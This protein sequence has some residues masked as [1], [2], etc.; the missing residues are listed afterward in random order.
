MTRTHYT[1]RRSALLPALLFLILSAPIIPVA[2]AAPEMRVID[3][4][5]G[6]RQGFEGRG[7]DVEILTVTG[8]EALSGTK[9]LLVTNRSKAWHGPALNVTYYVDPDVLYTVSVHVLPK[10]P[11]SS[12]FRLSTQIGEGDGA[13]FFNLDKQTVSR[14]DGWTELQGRFMYSEADYITIYIE[15]DTPDAEFYI[16]DVSF[17]AAGGGGGILASISLPSLREIYQDHFLLGSAFSRQDLAGQRFELVKRHFNVMTAG[18]AMK[19]DAL[20]GKNRGDYNFSSADAMIETLGEAGILT[21]G[22]TL[23]WHSQSAAWL[24]KNPDGTP[25]TRAEAR[26]NLEEFITTVAGHYA[27]RVLS[28]DVVN[29]AFTSNPSASADWRDGLRKGGAGNESAPWFGAYENGADKAAGESGADYIYDA[30]V[31]TRLA[32]PGALLYFLDFNEEYAGKREL[33]ALMT[34][35]LNGKWKADPRNTEPDRLLVEGLGLQAH[36]WTDH[37]KPEDVEATIRRWIQT[38]ADLVIG[39]LD[40]PAGSWSKYK[41]LDEAEEKKQA[42]L[43]AELFQI[44]KKYSDSISRVSIWGIDDPTSWRSGGSPLLFDENGGPKLAFYAVM[45]PEGYLA[46]EYDDANNPSGGE[47]TGVPAEP[48]EKGDTVSPS[49]EGDVSP[50]PDGGAEDAVSGDSETGFSRVALFIILGAAGCIL[51]AAIIL[52]LKRRTSS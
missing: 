1:Y 14:A 34:E 13:S 31:F 50:S 28:W 19:P 2:E 3:F 52:I 12:V 49:P 30:F 18:N 42:K 5:N 41:P 44:F 51:I 36:Y 8:E 46:G 43:Y 21:H 38:G 48:P 15:N 32:D 33:V 22:H 6:T 29:E 11:E 4:E 27:G 40:I 37:L 16:D 26:A 10:T 23:V 17:F 35:D 20:G 24:N 25:L 47:S 9:S 39:E 45:D 7:E